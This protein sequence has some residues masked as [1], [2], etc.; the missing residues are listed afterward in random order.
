MR[1]QGFIEIEQQICHHRPGGELRFVEPTG[2]LRFA[3]GN[4]L[5]RLVRRGLEAGQVFIER[6]CDDGVFLGGR[7]TSEHRAEAMDDALARRGAA[8]GHEPC[9][10]GTGR[11]EV[12][13]IVHQLERLERRVAALAPCTK[14]FAVRRVEID[15]ERRRR[16]PLEKN[17]ETAAVECVPV[18]L[19]VVRGIAADEPNRPQMFGGWYGRTACRRSSDSTVPRHAAPGPESPPHR[20][21]AAARASNRFSG[22]RARSSGDHADWRHA[23]V[24][25]S[26]LTSRFTSHPDS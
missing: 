9:G 13:H 7:E 6:V 3:I 18:I 17:I 24:I 25:T 26:D 1:G 20:A 11:F 23:A 21:A 5:F 12:L 8:F 2:R 19:R 22:S 14:L 15:Q 4:C 16:R 10:Q